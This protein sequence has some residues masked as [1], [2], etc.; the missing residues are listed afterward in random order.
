MTPAFAVTHR[1]GFR[2]LE[3]WQFNLAQVI[4]AAR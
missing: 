1:M 4:R 3:R 2:L